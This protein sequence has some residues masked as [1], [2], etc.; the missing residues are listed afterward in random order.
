M[1]PSPD[2]EPALALAWAT[3][4]AA[5][6]Q[7]A[8][9]RRA[10]LSAFTLGLA[11]AVGATFPDAAARGLVALAAM[12][13]AS[14]A[15]RGANAGVGR[16]DLAGVV[17]AYGAAVAAIGAIAAERRWAA[18]GAIATSGA[19]TLVF[20]GGVCATFAWDHPWPRGLRSQWVRDVPV[21][22]RR[23]HEEET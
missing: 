10:D 15:H 8:V 17:L 20:V 1:T 18:P 3:F 11:L 5:T 13:G 23:R 21:L 12:V 9:A 19:S 4:A 16:P 2:L 6:L 7:W 14:A 22:R